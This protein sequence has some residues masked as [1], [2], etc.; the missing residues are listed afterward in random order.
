MSIVVDEKSGNISLYQK[1]LILKILVTFGMEPLEWRKRSRRSIR[2]F[3]QMLTL[4]TDSQPTPIP[5]DDVVMRDKGYR[6][7]LGM[8]DIRY[9]ICRECVDAVR[10]RSMSIPLE[11]SAAHYRVLKDDN[12]IHDHLLQEWYDQAQTRHS[13]MIQAHGNQRRGK[14]S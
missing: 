7:A 4:L 2:L 6:K 13:Q 10:I 9:R 12:R 3:H 1:T 11:V 14:Y 5:N 8:L